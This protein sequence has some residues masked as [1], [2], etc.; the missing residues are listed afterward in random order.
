MGTGLT[1]SRRV[2]QTYMYTCMTII[3]III[4]LHNFRISAP[5]QCLAPSPGPL[6]SRD[7]PDTH[8]VCMLYFPVN[9]GNLDSTVIYVVCYIAL[10]LDNE[11]SVSHNVMLMPM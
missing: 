2:E 6:V 7:G 1:N 9:T 11:L 8:C 10:C 5:V 3:M 4:Y